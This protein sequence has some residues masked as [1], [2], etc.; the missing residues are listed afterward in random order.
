[1]KWVNHILISGATTAVINPALVPLAIAGSTAPDWLERVF[2]TFGIHVKHRAETH[3]VIYWA[4]ALTI[5]AFIDPTNHLFT[6]FFYGGL[7]H[8]LT[9][10]MTISGVP[11]SPLSDRKFNLFGGRFRTGD[12]IEY[13]ISAGVVLL[14]FSIIYGLGYK[15]DGGFFPFFFNWG[16]YYHEGLL[17]ASEWKKR[18]LQFF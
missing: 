15:D 18:R 6:A 12:P 2:N 13:A 1:M 11:F 8:C 17:D 14:C 3:I 16:N 9:D 10:A 5:S 7:T 4:V